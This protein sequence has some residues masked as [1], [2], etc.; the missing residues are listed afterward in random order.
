MMRGP[1]SAIL[2]AIQLVHTGVVVHSLQP[3]DGKTDWERGGLIGRV[4]T[5]R[6]KRAGFSKQAGE[7]VQDPVQVLSTVSYDMRGMKVGRQ[8]E[9]PS[10]GKSQ[11][12][13]THDLNG[14][15]TERAY[16]GALGL[17]SK[18]KYSYNSGGQLIEEVLYYPDGQTQKVRQVHN[19]DQHGRRSQTEV[20][21][22]HDPG[23]GISKRLYVYDLRGN[24]VEN[25]NYALDGSVSDKWVHTYTLDSTGNWIK[26]MVSHCLDEGRP[27]EVSC[28]PTDAT[29]RTIAY[30]E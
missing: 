18:E 15:L 28:R 25:I 14:R 10:D 5:I 22:A 17:I 1:N 27:G 9:S 2:I 23:S 26:R 13:L 4:E 30:Y 21:E 12:R 24:V 16:Y 6:I 20:Y 19:Y 7:W 8:E 29:Y 11:G 3:E